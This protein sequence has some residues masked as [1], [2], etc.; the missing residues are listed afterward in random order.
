M[1]WVK[2]YFEIKNAS[3]KKIVLIL[4]AIG[5]IIY[6]N[7]FFN[8][9]FWDDFDSIVNN[10]YI[11]SWSN[12]PKFFSQNLT[13][14]AGTINN[15][16]RPLLLISFAADYSIGK[17]SPFI[18]HLQ[19]TFWHILSAILIFLIF[20][21]ILKNNFIS[22]LT[23]LL[24]LIHPL[25]TEA[26]T[27]VAGR[28]DPMHSALMLLSFLFFLKSIEIPRIFNKK[29]LLSILF[30]IL[31]LLVKERAIIFPSLIVLY[32]ITLC[33]EKIKNNL[34]RKFKIV[35]PFF[36]VS[37]LYFILRIK[38]IHFNETF[39]FGQ[40]NNIGAEN[41]LHQLF[42]YF[43]GIWVY[44]GL[45]FWPA[46][47]YMEKS[48]GI[49]KTFFDFQTILGFL[50]IILSF[51]ATIYSF[52]NKKI[53]AFGL[54]W[55]YATL[56]PSLH[57]YPIQGLLYEHWLYFPLIGIFFIF[58]S[59][60]HSLINQ[61]KNENIK[62]IILFL[63]LMSALS[64]GIRTMI[65]NRDWDNPTRFYEKNISLGGYSA[66]V[67]TNLGMAYSENKKEEE[68]LAY[69]QKSIELSP[70]NY[71]TWY[72]MGNSYSSLKEKDKAIDSYTKAIEVNPYFFP[73]YYNQ[74]AIYIDQ[75]QVK[76]AIDILNKALEKDPD[77]LQTIYNLGVVYY[78]D[79]NKEKARENFK[80]VLEKDPYNPDLIRLIN[81]L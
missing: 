20:S 16:W 22:F 5:F 60:I 75:K 13:A 63:V 41:L 19:S 68:A 72:D 23:S 71:Q 44:T 42:A 1:D 64:L 7:T 26:T 11:R 81:S 66:R 35:L 36:L 55:F 50:I 9:F 33:P 78:N 51:I 57:I 45:I 38:F 31:A 8:Q 21:K 30:F 48:I 56:S 37:F 27:Y 65:R 17:I 52:K 54:I 29:Y 28:A 70:Y 34:K 77:N 3:T 61:T 59:L 69:Y 10:Q 74:A 6:C 39:D 18:Y 2:K 58:S 24:F 12:F 4:I 49:S 15:Y 76:E 53:I 79:G 73:S 62:K 46:R 47:L 80:K 43:K 14:G 67:Y 32:F 40:R 25:Q